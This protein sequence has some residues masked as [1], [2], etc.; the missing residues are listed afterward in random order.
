MAHTSLAS[1]LLYRTS[2]LKKLSVS[3]TKHLSPLDEIV[4]QARAKQAVEFAMSIQDKG[5]NIYAV[6][7]NGLGKR[8]MIMRYLE[9]H[10]L[11]EN[12]I[13]DWCYVS[14]FQDSRQPLV[15][16]LPAGMGKKLKKDIETLMVNLCK[17]MPVAFDSEM[18]HSR[19]D[20]IENLFK[21]QQEEALQALGAEAESH[22]LRLS[23][24]TAGDYQFM[25]MN[26]EKPHSE[27]SFDALSDK[28]KAKFDKAI[29][30]L[31]KSLR[32][33]IR[34]I[35]TWESDYIE[36]QLKL[37]ND[38]ASGVIKNKMAALKQN[39][40][41]IPEVKNHLECLQADILEHIDIF[42]EEDEDQT[43][44]AFASLDKK[45]PRRYQINVLVNQGD[46]HP[47][48]VEDSP[49]YH[50]IFGYVENTTFKGTVFTDFSMI[51]PGS[52]HKANGGV[53]LIDAAKLLERPYVWDGL[54]RAL[55]AQTINVSSLEREV[56]L[57]GSISLE[58]ES[59]PLNLKIILFGDYHTYSLLQQYDPDFNELFRITADFEDEIARNDDTELKYAEFVSSICHDNE[60]LHCNKDAI[61][62]VI[63]HSSREAGD[64]NKL[65]LHASDIA[66]LLREANFQAK[67]LQ[68][69]LIR[70]SHVE[71][72]LASIELRVS[73]LRDQVM[74]GFTNNTT[75][76]ET[77]GKA[78][79]QVNAL[80]V[81]STQ[82]FAFGTPNRIT[83]TTAF[84]E[85]GV[86]DIER[87][88][89][90]GGN[91]HSKGVMILTAYLSSILGKTA[92][93]PL[94]THIAFEQSYSGVDGDSASMAE[95]CAIISSMSGAPLRQE[96]AITGSMN[97]FGEAQP[98]GGV[99]EKIEGFFDVCTIKGPTSAQGVIIPRSNIHNLMLRKDIIHAVE[100]GKFHIYAIDHVS[101]ALELLTGLPAGKLDS[102]HKFKTGT[103]Y[104][105]AY[106]KLNKLREKDK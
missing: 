5:Y 53:L 100:K 58:P 31:K 7:Q 98:I 59:I 26:G 6:G 44:L 45:L 80:S 37:D 52:I 8:T 20:V 19:S 42:L 1:D 55:S 92:K 69:T 39:Y 30:K 47:I 93:I 77:K 21:E 36:K 10:W 15:L 99:N 17:A 60:L 84:G 104:H 33:F 25:A 11:P 12:E 24:T 51:R 22:H 18:Y 34:D 23:V 105:K 57:S 2:G 9:H 32:L 82:Q 75:L 48:V 102:K 13:Y 61:A 78:I 74:E 83:A 50:N 3:S 64:Q 88:V 43:A 71:K 35:S 65:S 72:A 91:I 56:S 106:E 86:L 96:L 14:N 89:H 4:G 40:R 97:Q 85:G 95:F 16:K 81:I 27:E 90:L 101:D 54:K 66:N 62:R 63:E 67:S 49:T 41:D 94:T 103:L 76:I 46:K 38:V 28:K 87:S 29:S 70:A 73:R 68:S 79:G